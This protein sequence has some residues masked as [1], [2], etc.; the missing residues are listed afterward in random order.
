[1]ANKTDPTNTRV[2]REREFIPAFTKRFE[3]LK[4]EIRTK[5][6]YDEDFF[7][8]R[9][10]YVTADD[11]T[12]PV[13]PQAK[14]EFQTWLEKKI[15]D[16]ILE[17][18]SRRQLRNGEHYT[19][20]YIRSAAERGWDDAAQK[21][22]QQGIDVTPEDLQSTFEM[23]V[24]EQQLQDAYTRTFDDLKNIT[25][26]MQTEIRRTLTRGLAEG[27][28]PRKM[29]TEMNGRVDVSLT[30][31]RRLARTEVIRN[32]N[33]A[34]LTRFERNNISEVGG[35]AEWSTAGDSRV[36]PICAALDGS[37]YSIKKARGRIPQHPNCRCTW[38]PV[39]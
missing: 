32:Y 34:A 8:L 2:L 36:C 15:N 27:W 9:A 38:L 3:W 23:G 13:D 37:V 33:E 17:P 22:E 24:G 31:A 25:D 16:G 19:G 11:Y 18:T 14:D 26:D 4:G 5:V 12:Y 21:L 28:N 39:I 35:K 30:R 20:R 7:S 10:S 29:A 1:M 6:G